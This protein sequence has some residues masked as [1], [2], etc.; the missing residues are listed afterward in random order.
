MYQS[1]ILIVKLLFSIFCSTI[2]VKNSYI[3]LSNANMAFLLS[4]MSTL[5]RAAWFVSF[6]YFKNS[7]KE[8]IYVYHVVPR[9]VYVVFVEFLEDFLFQSTEGYADELCS[10][11]EKKS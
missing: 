1:Y 4:M 9:T 11:T 2:E 8:F 6:R 10:R 7:L 5:V 3:V